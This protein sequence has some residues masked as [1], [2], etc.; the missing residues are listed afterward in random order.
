MVRARN[1]VHEEVI[2][3]NTG[4]AFQLRKG[5]SIR[6]IGRTTVD[7]VVLNLHNLSERFDQGRTKANQAKIFLT[8]GDV[9]FS[10]HNNVMM[11]ILEDTFPGHHD[12]QKGMC[13]RKRHEMV[14]RGEAKRVHWGGKQL[15]PQRFEDIPP[16]GCWEN[17]SEALKPWA[18]S[19]DDVPNPW[20]IF[21]NMRIDGQTGQMWWDH[22]ELDKDAHVELRAE[23]DLLVAA[24]HCPGGVGRT[25]HVQVYGP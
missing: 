13:S 18:I 6:I 8:K 21:Q 24:S 9:L 3:Y 25:T 19:A 1:L 17:L 7:F 20:N 12:L 22:L 4:R 2:P 14:F 11:T 5:Q 23:M 16:R 10:K 15:N